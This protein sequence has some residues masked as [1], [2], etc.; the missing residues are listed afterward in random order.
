M[1]EG[2]PPCPGHPLAGA[3]AGGECG[4]RTRGDIA[5]TTVF[6]S[7]ALTASIPPATCPNA[8]LAAFVCRPGHSWPTGLCA[9]LGQPPGPHFESYTRGRPVPPP[10]NPDRRPEK[11]DFCP[12]LEHTLSDSGTMGAPCGRGRPQCVIRVSR[13]CRTPRGSPEARA[14]RSRTGTGPRT[15]GPPRAT[16]VRRRRRSC[17]RP[18]RSSR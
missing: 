8:D 6:K 16:R 17:H 13:C 14:G 18:V 1:S 12:F 7:V 3:F 15:C 10:S 2:C 11:L 4:I 9:R 5:A